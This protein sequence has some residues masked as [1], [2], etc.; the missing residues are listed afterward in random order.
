MNKIN[1][2]KYVEVVAKWTVKLFEDDNMPLERRCGLMMAVATMIC[3]LVLS[4]YPLSKEE[5]IKQLDDLI[6]GA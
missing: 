4:A 5:L 1:D 2:D 3:R 6:G